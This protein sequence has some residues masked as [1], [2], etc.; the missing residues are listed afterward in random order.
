MERLTKGLNQKITSY[1]LLVCCRLF[2][3][4]SFFL[5]PPSR[6]SHFSTTTKHPPSPPTS[7]SS[8]NSCSSSTSLQLLDFNPLLISSVVRRV[9]CL[10]F[11]STATPLAHHIPSTHRYP[12]LSRSICFRST[13]VPRYS[14]TFRHF[15]SASLS[16]RPAFASIYPA[17]RSCY[18][19]GSITRSSN[20]NFHLRLR[21]RHCHLPLFKLQLSHHLRPPSACFADPFPIP[22]VYLDS[23]ANTIKIKKE[24]SAFK[25]F[26]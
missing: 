26:Q 20:S 23:R 14:S 11:H 12:V 3:S 21:P 15:H 5:S 19:D 16:F 17:K 25:T 7:I 10:R 8:S 18:P 22:K 13:F 6:P 9:H 4:F 1:F 24:F 2:S